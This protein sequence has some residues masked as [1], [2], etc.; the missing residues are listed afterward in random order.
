MKEYYE[1]YAWTECPFC[2]KAREFLSSRGLQFMFCCIDESKELL[3]H[4]KKKYQWTTVPLI[5]KVDVETGDK[6]FVG[7]YTDLVKCLGDKS[8]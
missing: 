2:I 1:I 6:E 3:D 5:V 4:I 7:G 8:E